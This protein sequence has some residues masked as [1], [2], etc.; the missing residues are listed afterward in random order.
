M[1]ATAVPSPSPTFDWHF[2]L[3][4]SAVPSIRPAPS[5]SVDTG[6]WSVDWHTLLMG[7]AVL[8]LASAFG[9]RWWRSSEVARDYLPRVARHGWAIAVTGIFSAIGVA[10][11][12][13]QPPSGQPF[14]PPWL[15][16][17]LAFLSTASRSI[18]RF[19]RCAMNARVQMP[20][21]TRRQR[22]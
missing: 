6:S 14:V 12:T 19:K 10:A 17:V 5:P 7:V 13:I 20:I 1:P 18:E 15:F 3:P 22:R 9:W 8:S 2:I 11:L 16:F 21:E 4:T